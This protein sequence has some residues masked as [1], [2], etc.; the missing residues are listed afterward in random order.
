MREEHETWRRK[1]HLLTTTGPC[2]CICET[3]DN[4]R[5]IS[6]EHSIR[7]RLEKVVHR[8]EKGLSERDKELRMRSKIQGT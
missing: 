1:A 8:G 4:Q 2:I 5:Q 3:Q 6:T 7:E